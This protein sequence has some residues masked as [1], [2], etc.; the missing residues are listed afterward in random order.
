M[1]DAAEARLFLAQGLWLQ[2]VA[3]P[4]AAT[5]GPALRWALEAASGGEPLPPVGFV[6]DLG[7]LV[8]GQ[9]RDPRP[10]PAAADLPGWPP[11]LLRLYEDLVLG[12][13]DAD[14]TVARASDALARYRGRDRDRGLAFVLDQFRRRAGFGGVLLNPAVVKAAIEAPAD[15][16]LADGWESLAGG[17][18]LPVLP[19]L[20]EGLIAAVRDAHDAL[21]PEDVFELEHGTALAAFGERVALRQVVRAAADFAAGV[22]PERPRAVARRHDVA[23]RVLDEDLYPVGG[24]AS[25]ATRGSIESLLPWQLVYMGDGDRPDLFDV[26]FVR[27]ELLYYSRDENQFFR[28]RR[29]YLVALYPDLVM[30]RVKD[31]GLPRQRVVLL[32]GM[33]AALVRRLTEW[34]SGEAIVFEFLFVRQGDREPLAA[35]RALTDMVLR[36]A[37]A[38]GTALTEVVAEAQL[39]ARC[40]AR[41]R[42]GLCQGLAVAASDRAFAA[43]GVAV[44]RLR[45]DR[46]RP[47]LGVDDEPAGEVEADDDLAAWSA[48]LERLLVLWS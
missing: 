12:K 5:V 9:G 16:F 33:L 43:D 36:E 7:N 17:G 1:N 25:I 23:T 6:A 2:R 3:A 35:E 27:D 42:R 14:P 48:A 45:L 8:L 22:A 47:A 19:A 30:T 4:R 46:P 34:L 10:D 24:F 18:L 20:Y 32:L 15:E 28:R 37:I 38:N 11:G 44:S 41:S 29:S 40:A 13:L 31:V 39:A 21:G 26:K